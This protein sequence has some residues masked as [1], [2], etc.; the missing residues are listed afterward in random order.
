MKISHTVRLAFLALCLLLV[1]CGSDAV[2][3]DQSVLIGDVYLDCC[4]ECKIHGSCGPSEETGK[5]IVLLGTEPAFPGVSAIAFQGLE[6]GTQVEV[7]DTKVVAGIEQQ[8]GKAVEIRFYA[9]QNQDGAS[10]VWVPGFCVANQ[11]P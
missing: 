2:Y 4:K 11:A 8:T 1:A 5:E 3:G 6:E 9:V 10:A 7:L